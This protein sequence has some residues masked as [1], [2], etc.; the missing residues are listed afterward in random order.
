MSIREYIMYKYKIYSEEENDDDNDYSCNI[1]ANDK[2]N[3]DYDNNQTQHQQNVDDTL[4]NGID[5]LFVK[6]AAN[7]VI[8]IYRIVRRLFV[9]KDRGRAL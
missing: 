5:G 1:N 3:D 4:N 7:V 6:N 9:N 2:R 8:S